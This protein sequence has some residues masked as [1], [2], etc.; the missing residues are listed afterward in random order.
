MIYLISDLHGGEKMNGIRR[1][2]ELCNPEDLLMILG[3]VGLKFQDTEENRKFTE[4]FLSLKQPIAIVEGNHENHPYLNSFPKE[5]WC[6]GVVRRISESMVLLQR[7]NI[8]TIQGKTFFAMGGCKSSPKW[9]EAGLWFDG[10]EPTQE[11]LSLAYRNLEKYNHRV[12]YILT[13]KYL[14]YA[15]QE[16]APMTLE[17]LTKYID[18]KVIFTHWYSGHWHKTKQIDPLHT[19]VCEEPF[20]IE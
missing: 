4:W 8:Y 10:E 2:L 16:P 15:E 17:G 19:V 14:N 20:I 3:D 13:H 9:K 11:E 18:Q 5:E 1:A 12:D 7:G 6:G